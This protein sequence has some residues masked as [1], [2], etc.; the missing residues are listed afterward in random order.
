M[1]MYHPLYFVA[2]KFNYASVERILESR[3]LKF[4]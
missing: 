2:R 3:H 1:S 4:L